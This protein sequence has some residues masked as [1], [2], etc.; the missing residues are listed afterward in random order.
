MYYVC[1]DPIEISVF[2]NSFYENLYNS[3]F[4]KDGYESYIGH[5]QIYVP[6]IED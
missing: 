6:V 2:V 4:Q 3:Q 5:I 1:K